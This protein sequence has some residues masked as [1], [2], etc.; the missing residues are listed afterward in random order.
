M[1]S[2]L[3]AEN[4][5]FTWDEKKTNWKI[6]EP[7]QAPKVVYCS[8]QKDYIINSKKAPNMYM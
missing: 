4:K 8:R 3:S 5:I 6:L 2:I 1:D 7:P